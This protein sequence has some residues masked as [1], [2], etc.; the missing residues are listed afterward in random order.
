QSAAVLDSLGERLVV[1]LSRINGTALENKQILFSLISGFG[2]VQKPVVSEGV[3][4]IKTIT[5]FE[6]KASVQFLNRGGDPITKISEVKAEVVDSTQFWVVFTI[7][8]L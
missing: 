1:R 2:D 7:N 3:A 6:G 4:D 8:S 5:D